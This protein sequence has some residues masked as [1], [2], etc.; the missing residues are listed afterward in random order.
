MH[1][2][3]DSKTRAILLYGE[4]PQLQPW[5]G[6][7]RPQKTNSKEPSSSPIHPRLAFFQAQHHSSLVERP[8]S[9]SLNWRGSSHISGWGVFCSC[10]KSHLCWI[11]TRKE[12]K[13]PPG[14]LRRGLGRRLRWGKA[15]RIEPPRPLVRWWLHAYVRRK[16]LPVYCLETGA[17][18][19]AAPGPETTTINQNWL[20][21][22]VVYE[23]HGIVWVSR[24]NSPGQL[25]KTTNSPNS[26]NHSLVWPSNQNRLLKQKS[27][28]S[29]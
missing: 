12:R 15:I 5:Q 13:P 10:R 23:V 6:C 27:H 3:R 4:G 18:I 2:S 11:P 16:I 19:Q 1:S 29:V 25:L 8:F 14:S 28:L 21:C 22:F 7:E 9:S 26:S 24:E 17:S 20:L